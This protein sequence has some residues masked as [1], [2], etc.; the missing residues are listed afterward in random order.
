MRGGVSAT[1][2]FNDTDVEDLKILGKII[3][4]NIES[5]KK[6]GLNLI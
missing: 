3:T 5:T 2:L 4:E 1:V 6:S